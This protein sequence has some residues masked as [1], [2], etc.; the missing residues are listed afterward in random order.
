MNGLF[1][2]QWGVRFRSIAWWVLVM[3]G[4]F[5]TIQVIASVMGLRYIGAGVAA[6]NTITVSGHGEFDAAPDTATFTFSVVSDKSTAA[7]AQADAT[8]KQNAVSAYLKAQGIAD[9]DIQTSGYN[10]NPQYDY[11]DGK[12]T[13]RGYEARQSTTVKVHD[14]TKAGDLLVGVGQQGATEVSGLN[15]TF[16]DPNAPQMQARQKAIAD[17]KAKADELAK[18]L[19]VSVV[20][21]TAF[22]ESQ[23][24]NIIRPIAAYAGMGMGAADKA[25][26]PAI[27]PGQ[28]TVTDD[29]TITYE[30]R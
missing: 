7:A 12:Q 16:D 17:A 27:N 11:T 23:G 19:G 13:L 24:G 6:A 14:L 20:R 22:N 26:A 28:N 1:E 5:L 4:V 30:I 18:E 2:G 15:F 21:V 3:L 8:Q 10:V 9:K 29:V 25:A